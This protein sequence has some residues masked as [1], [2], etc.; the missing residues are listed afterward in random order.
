M[1]ERL[2]RVFKSFLTQALP[3]D[4]RMETEKTIDPE[5]EKFERELK[6]AKQ[7]NQATSEQPKLTPEALQDAIEVELIEDAPPESEGDPTD[8]V[9][10]KTLG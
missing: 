6:R 8:D 2:T 10:D 7:H 5:I 3:I 9:P 4:D 1:L